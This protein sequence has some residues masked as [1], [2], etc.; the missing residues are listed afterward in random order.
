MKKLLVAFA[1]IAVA[2]LAVAGK[3]T[4]TSSDRAI[5]LITKA[6]TATGTSDSAVFRGQFDAALWGTFV[7][8]AQLQQ[9][10][11]GGTTWIPVSIDSSGSPASYTAPVA[12]TAFEPEDGVLY[13]WE[14][15]A[16]T[17]G[18]INARISK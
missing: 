5:V 7:G 16:Y 3:P 6:F 8:T 17:S 14:C 15:T 10:F 4:S 11:D 13:R 18:T 1:L 9:S 12:V 2:T